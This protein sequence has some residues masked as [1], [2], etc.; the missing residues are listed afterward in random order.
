MVMVVNSKTSISSLKATGK[1]FSLEKAV[2]LNKG[3]MVV[4]VTVKTYQF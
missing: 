1:D 3:P 2:Q 4:V